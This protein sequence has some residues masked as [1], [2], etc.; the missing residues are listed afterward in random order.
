MTRADYVLKIFSIYLSDCNNR[1]L[2]W[3]LGYINM[4]KIVVEDPILP[5][6]DLASL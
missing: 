2:F 3:R 6:D 5:Q 4:W 1:G